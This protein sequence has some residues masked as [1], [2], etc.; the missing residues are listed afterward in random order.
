MRIE[1]G[2]L[3]IRNA[4]NKDCGQLAAWWNDGNVM[5][6]AG[7]P[8]GLNTTAEEIWQ[9]IREDSDGTRRRLMIEYKNQPIGEMS[10]CNLGSGTAEIGIK[11][12]DARY[13]D[14]GLGRVL[15]CML[16]KTLFSMGYRKIVLDTNLNNTRAQH[17]YELLG[18]QKLRVNID[19]WRDQ[20]GRPQ[21][22]VDYELTP[23]RLIDDP[24]FSGK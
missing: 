18:F 19:S 24:S 6:H 16:I 8:L 11:I 4:E 15:L 9:K 1:N 23:E 10:Y 17:V 12:C 13:H 5:A 2:D 22:S 14:K 7:F 20:L 3:C 21:S